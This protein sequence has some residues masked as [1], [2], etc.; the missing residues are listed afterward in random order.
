MSVRVPKN[1]VVF[2][3]DGTLISKTEVEDGCFVDAVRRELGD[4]TVDPDWS[5]FRHVTDTG[6]VHELFLRHVGRP[7]SSAE[8]DR[9]AARYAERLFAALDA[10]P[11][12]GREIP[13]ASALLDRLQADG[14]WGLSIATGNW[15]SVA[16]HKWR[17]A[18]L[19]GGDLPMATAE[20]SRRRTDI[21]RA[22]VA[23]AE[24]RERVSH[25]ERVVS[26]GDA[27][28][29]LRAARSVGAAFVGVGDGWGSEGRTDAPGTL[30]DFR[31]LDQVLETFAQAT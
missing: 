22:A 13:G 2:D 15:E 18:G 31:D 12:E 1:L 20:D 17:R 7:P 27:E 9:I 16:R 25:F 14:E 30:R 24:R 23:R 28:W 10:R 3:I 29:D 11:E 19:P 4:V 26:V 8:V 21:L 5:T 6:L